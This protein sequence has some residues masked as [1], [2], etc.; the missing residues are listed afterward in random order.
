MADEDDLGSLGGG[1][2]DS[3]NTEHDALPTPTFAV[4]EQQPVNQATMMC[5]RGP[6]VHFWR[7]VLRFP[8]AVKAV[9]TERNWTC[10]ASPSEEFELNEKLVY[11]CDRWWPRA[12]LR[13]DAGANVDGFITH[14]YDMP[15]HQRP[16]HRADLHAAWEE[17]LRQLGYDFS[18]RDFDP[19]ANPDDSP[20]QRGR[21]AP[22]DLES[23]D[24]AVAAA[25]AEMAEIDLPPA[26]SIPEE[27][28]D[29]A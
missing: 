12:P 2:Q 10:I 19:T 20:E 22:G 6:C 26:G 17:G 27:E 9:M 11:F 24:E 23:T 1:L 18:W 28:E 13:N 16:L 3:D 14:N 15:E 29:D 21:S 5:L 8:S 7:L 4:E 25:M